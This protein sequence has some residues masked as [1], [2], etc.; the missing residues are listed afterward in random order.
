MVAKRGSWLNKYAKTSFLN[1]ENGLPTRIQ[2]GS[3]IEAQQDFTRPDPGV[4]TR[5][6]RRQFRHPSTIG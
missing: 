1:V 4:G 2:H 6:L 5:I 3:R